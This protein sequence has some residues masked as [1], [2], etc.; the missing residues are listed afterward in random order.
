MVSFWS[1]PLFGALHRCGAGSLLTT[2]LQSGPE[3]SA[4]S[5][6]PSEP[7]FPDAPSTLH[8]MKS[9]MQLRGLMTIIRD[10]S[11]S[12]ADFVF[13]ADRVIRLLIEEGLNFL[14]FREHTVITPTDSS[15]EGLAFTG[16]VCGVSI[17]RAGEAMEKALRECCRSI[18]VGKILIQRDES[19]AQPK[20]FYAKLPPDIADRHVLLLDPM[21]ATGG[22]AIKA[23]EVLIEQ[24]VPEDRII[25]INLVAAPEGV[26]A[27]SKRFPHTH[28]ITAEVDDSLSTSK[29]IMPG[30]GDFGCRYFGTDE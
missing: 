15:Y 4:R 3:S 17:M 12:R 13:Y 2:H 8:V 11:T 29:H 5:A 10:R 25:F 24:G 26:L 30:L 7:A 16:R 28:I 23:V 1:L 14:P 21:L 9:T 6:S 19:T 20:L 18:R 27:F 22:S